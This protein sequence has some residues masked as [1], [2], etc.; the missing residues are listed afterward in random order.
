MC[1]VCS[2]SMPKTFWFSGDRVHCQVVRLGGQWVDPETV[3]VR[4]YFGQDGC[5]GRDISS[6]GWFGSFRFLSS[7]LNYPYHMGIVVTKT[8]RSWIRWDFDSWKNPWLCQAAHFD[9]SVSSPS[10]PE[11]GAVA[12]EDVSPCHGKR[13]G[14]KSRRI[15]CSNP[16]KSRKNSTPGSPG[17]NSKTQRGKEEQ[18]FG[19][20]QC[21]H[22]TKIFTLVMMCRSI[23]SSLTELAP[24]KCMHGKCS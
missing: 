16:K 21:Q 20:G 9:A 24:C 14:R 2:I 13:S 19:G 15:T 23:L 6:K 3:G 11:I 7:F 4:I 8:W 1:I 22:C 10:T 5:I 12:P 18:H 17:Q